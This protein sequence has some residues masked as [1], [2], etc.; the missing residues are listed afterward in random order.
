MKNTLFVDH[1]DRRIVMDRTFYKN[2][3]NTMSDEY[4]HLRRCART[5]R[6]TALSGAKSGRTETRR[7]TRA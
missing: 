6:S 1:K 2:S 4:D 3:L 5:I 7:P